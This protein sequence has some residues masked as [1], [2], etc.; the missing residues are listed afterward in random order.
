MSVVAEVHATGRTPGSGEPLL[1]VQDLCVRFPDVYGPIDVIQHV[2]LQVTAGECVGLVGES[3]SGKS[4]LGLSI[5][6]LVPRGARASGEIRFRGRN[7]LELRERRLAQLRGAEIAM[8]Y[9]DALTSLD[10]AF[11]IGRSLDEVCRRGSEYDPVDLLELVSLRGAERLLKAYPHELSGGQRQRVLI[12]LA[13]ARHPSLVVA[14]EPTTALDVT[15]Q[16]QVVALLRRL[17][18]QVGFAMVL[19]SHDLSLVAQLADRIAVMYAGQL[20]ESRRR[21]SLL[22]AP[23]HP[24]TRG[25]LDA[26]LSLEERDATLRVIPGTVP[27][28]RGFASGCR[29]RDRCPRAQD[30]CAEHVPDREPDGQGLLACYHPVPAL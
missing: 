9:Q 5:M 21:T 11:T 27:S 22:R 6:G 13:L 30:D 20:V 18:E 1:V 10:P 4:L 8:V 16:A 25:L 3:G 15:V 28:P 29:F 2:D 26:R 24:Y 19:I 23:R 7:L 17:Q 12:A 14:D